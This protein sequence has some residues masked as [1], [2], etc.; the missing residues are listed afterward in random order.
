MDENSGAIVIGGDY[1]GLGVVRSLGRHRIP[2]W[3]LTDSH[4]IAA[5]SRYAARSFA[6]PSEAADQ[7]EFLLQLA[8]QYA[9]D[10]WLLIP[11]GDETAALVARHR[12]AL[13]QHF[14]VTVPAWDVLQY[15]YD[16]RLTNRLAAEIG[17]DAP[18]T[19]YPKDSADLERAA[20]P[21]PVILKPAIKEGFN[22]FVHSKAWLARNREELLTRYRKACALVTEEIIMVQEMIP[23]DGQ[24]QFSYAALCEAG[25]PI[26]SMVARRTRQYPLDF[27]RSSSYVESIDQPEV[28]AASRCILTALHYTGLIEIEF[29]RD[30]RNGKFKLLDLNPRVWGWHTLGRRFGGDFPYLLW[31]LMHDQCV[32]RG[33]VPAGVHWVRA[34]TDIP[35]AMTQMGRG[36]LSP[37]AYVRSLTSPLEFAILAV[38]DPAPALVEVPLL[39]E[40][41]LRR[42]AA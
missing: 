12:E 13:E 17:V 39:S 22:A 14:R 34:V 5:Y 30:P 7:A 23:G 40:L 42:G 29:K 36:T 38:D 19:Y 2:V 18:W 4:R 15:A 1:R 25:S 35:A 27:G 6:F 26:V 31:Q 8:E 24:A 16:K 37:A 10:G 33:R 21:F 28:E 32:P 11:T 9:L 20:L 3:V 41:A